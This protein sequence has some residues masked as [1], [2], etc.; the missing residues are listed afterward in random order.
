MYS[1]LKRASGDQAI[2]LFPT[3]RDYADVSPNSLVR[4]YY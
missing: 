2:S 4:R 3:T 1:N